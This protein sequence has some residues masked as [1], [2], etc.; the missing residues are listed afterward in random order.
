[1][2]R[3][4]RRIHAH[5]AMTLIELLVVIVII[6]VL[7]ALLLPAVQAARERTRLTQCTSH[8]RQ[9]AIAVDLYADARSDALPALWHTSQAR[10]WNNFSWR[11]SIL[12]MLEQQTAYDALH[13]ADPPLSATNREPLATTITPF[14]CPSTPDY[15][16]HITDMGFAESNYTDLNVAA[17]DYV[18]VHDVSAAIQQ[19]PMRGA[20]NGGPD[21][22]STVPSPAGDNGVGPAPPIDRFSP[23]L[24][25]LPGNRRLITDG[26]SNTAVI[27]EQ[28]GKP[29]DYGPD[30]QAKIIE[31]SEGP[32]G[33]GDFSSF[34]ADG[35]N[36]RNHSGPYGFHLGANVAMADGSVHV[37]A[38]GMAEEVMAALL[39]RDAA[40]IISPNDWR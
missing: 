4:Q 13:L 3:A 33:T 15:T 34:F 26:L 20:F 35:V 29:F 17:H 38:E 24:R 9:Q 22:Q 14:Q 2:S 16:R 8:L 23:E 32:W 12:P 19:L 11:I 31:P 25:I 30:G 21:L 28:A 7:V 18:A 1:M 39:S 37:W 27:V 5:P 10:P 6:G 36:R 40:E